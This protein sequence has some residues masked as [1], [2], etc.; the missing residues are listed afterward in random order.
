MSPILIGYFPKLTMKAPEGLK[1]HGV[2]EVC[3]VSTC[4]SHGPGDW[5]N[6]WRHNEM[7]VYDT[8][9]IAWSVVPSEEMEQFDLYAYGVYP[10]RFAHGEQEHYAIA[11]NKV[12]PLSRWFTAIGYDVVS[13]TNDTTFECSPLSCNGLATEVRTNRFCL[14]DTEDRAFEIARRFSK[15]E[16]EPGPYHVVQVWRQT[17][18]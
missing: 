13:R 7:W 17:L 16:P 9:E 18:G 4:V 10:V 6:E 11:V 8:E 12:R 3:S 2:E 14:L 15:S 5:I 1:A